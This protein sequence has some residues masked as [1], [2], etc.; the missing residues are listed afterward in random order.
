MSTKQVT[1]SDQAVSN[2]GDIDSDA[3]RSIYFTAASNCEPRGIRTFKATNA[4]LIPEPGFVGR[5][6]ACAL[7][8]L[9]DAASRGWQRRGLLPPLVAGSPDDEPRWDWHEIQAWMRGD[10]SS[11]PR[12]LLGDVPPVTTG[13]RRGP[14]PGTG[15]RPRKDVAPPSNDPTTNNHRT[16]ERLNHD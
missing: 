15:G 4:E 12:D 7:L 2:S 9:S 1:E 11:A 14:A 13:T 16:V 5:R 10:K 6:R 8:D 3:D